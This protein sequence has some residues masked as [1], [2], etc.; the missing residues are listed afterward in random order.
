MTRPGRPENSEAYRHFY[1]PYRS[2]GDLP[3]RLLPL[4]RDVPARGFFVVAPETE[5]LLRTHFPERGGPEGASIGENG[6][7]FLSPASG[8]EKG[9]DPFLRDVLKTL[10]KLTDRGEEGEWVL[11]EGTALFT[12]R[13][14]PELLGR[15]EEELDRLSRERSLRIA[16]L[17]DEESFPFSF[18][19]RAL[20]A[21]KTFFRRGSLIPNPLYEVPPRFDA[22]ETP[23]R[24]IGRFRDL[25]FRQEESTRLHR[26]L[27][28]KS[29][30][31]VYVVQEGRFRYINPNA[32]SYAGYGPEE[33]IGM[34]SMSIV[35]PEDRNNLKI[36]AM[37]MMRGVRT[38]PYE[39][40]ILRKDGKV[41]W[42]LETL[43]PILFEGKP[44]I[45]GNSMDITEKNEDREALRDSEQQMREI[46]N[47]LPDAT[48]VI[49]RDGT[50][51]AWNRAIEEMTGIP[52]A[53]MLGKK[54]REYSLP[55]HGKIQPI[56]IDFALAPDSIRESAYTRFEK[57]GSLLLAEM[58]FI[59]PRGEK[60]YLW[61]KAS[62]I[63]D[64][65]GAVSGAIETIRDITELKR[66]EALLR[67]EKVRM[68]ELFEGSPEAI[69]LTDPDGR[70][71][72]INQHFTKLFGYTPAEAGGRSVDE[73]IVPADLPEEASELTRRVAGGKPLSIETVRQTKNGVPVQVSI[74]ATPIQIDEDQIGIYAIY[75]DISERKRFETALR[76]N[77]ERYRTIIETIEDGYYETDLHG[78][79]VFANDSLLRILACSREEVI[80]TSFR[81]FTDR[82]NGQRIWLACRKVFDTGDPCVGLEWVISRKG[83]EL[84]SLEISIS[85]IRDAAD[86]PTGFRGILRDITERI[87]SEETIRKL[88]YH[89][90]LTGLPNRFLFYDRLTMAVARATRAGN[91]VAVIMLDLDKFKEVNDSLG[92]T[93]GDLL[94]K[95]VSERL[96]RIMR[97]G[98][99]VARMGG[100][101][102]MVIAPDIKSVDGGSIVGKKIVEAVRNPFLCD[103]HH[104]A[105]TTSLGIAFFPEHG[106]NPEI[107]VQRADIAMYRAKHSGRNLWT[108]YEEG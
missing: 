83:G 21:H 13:T 60:R 50:V 105:I 97:R 89:D 28:E 45:L 19:Q 90:A 5:S 55:F 29:F 79:V 84:R 12:P 69:A 25:L 99:T 81:G 46:V 31:G 49:D 42:I 6:P 62:P 102:F 108:I 86:N 23:A 93:V 44:A 96:V 57:K 100:D 75:R 63:Y 65:A 73:L 74:L 43:T 1:F 9:T 15:F 77:E 103:G 85:L 92:H 56:L 17:Y 80:G 51:I 47:F 24:A 59:S 20:L 8:Q 94:L 4:F 78:R 95:A 107:L 66:A 2:A 35:L 34:D 18:L 11:L 53:Q 88:A 27:A 41:R 32:A 104:L 14:D 87:R 101:E 67:I 10:E 68:E 54:N 38:S 7:L 39:F 58:D 64:R 26:I 40:R 33:M 70:V 76:E 98:D 91:M 52:V 48:L 61:L 3:E 16:C 82:E 37:E 30:A 71:I 106:S 72:R 36:S 22:G